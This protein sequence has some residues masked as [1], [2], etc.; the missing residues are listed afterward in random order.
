MVR[1]TKRGEGPHPGLQP[2]IPLHTRVSPIRSPGLQ[3]L[4]PLHTRVSPIRSSIKNRSSSSSR[5][6]VFQSLPSNLAGRDSWREETMA[7]VVERRQQVEC[8]V[9]LEPRPTAR[10]I[11]F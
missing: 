6:L 8:L 3:P 5:A 4:I 9:I 10:D 2:L 1:S 11:F 7:L